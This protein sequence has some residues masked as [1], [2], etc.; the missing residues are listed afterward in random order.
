[1][2]MLMV[3]WRDVDG[4]LAESMI[5][6]RLNKKQLQALYGYTS[7]QL[8]IDSSFKKIC[9]SDLAVGTTSNSCSRVQLPA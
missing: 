4:V 1:M 6:F 8:A 7:R 5:L 3:C 2:L 9:G